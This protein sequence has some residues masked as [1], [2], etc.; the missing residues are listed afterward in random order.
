MVETT[1]QKHECRKIGDEYTC[2]SNNRKTYTQFVSAFSTMG[3]AKI[4]STKCYL[5]NISYYF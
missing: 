3:N 5:I 2:S 4:V 1:A